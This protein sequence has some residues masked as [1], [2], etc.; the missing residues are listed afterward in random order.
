MNNKLFVRGKAMYDR[1]KD[2]LTH[3]Y[4]DINQ[5]CT[6]RAVQ[7]V[8]FTATRPLIVAK[9]YDGKALRLL[10]QV[11]D[12]SLSF[13]GTGMG[14]ELDMPQC[15]DELMNFYREWEAVCAGI[16]DPIKTLNGFEVSLSALFQSVLA[17]SADE[18]YDCVLHAVNVGKPI[19]L[20][21]VK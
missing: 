19:Q 10:V 11:G 3:G 17:D 4:V 14:F 8:R 6:Q 1:V 15:N 20:K 13:D 7:V 21:E 12:S 9:W 5:N 16:I 18:Q 2:R